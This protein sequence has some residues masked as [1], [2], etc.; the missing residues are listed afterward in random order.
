MPHEEKP[1]SIALNGVRRIVL[2]CTP[3]Q[4]AV[5]AL[6]HLLTEGWI[7]NLDDVGAISVSEDETGGLTVFVEADAEQVE[8]TEMVRRHQTLHGC[9][10]RH[11]LD[12]DPFMVTPVDS[13]GIPLDGVHLLRALFTAVDDMAPGGGVHACSISDGERL[14]FTST[15]VARHC[16][17]DRAVGLGIREGD[18]AGM[19]LVSTARISGAMALKAARAGLGWIAS[20]SVATT[21]ASEIADAFGVLLIERAGKSHLRT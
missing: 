20:R 17:L 19:G 15:D 12:C 3:T 11:V 6:G 4:P 8:T 16:A 21:L 7:R 2:S 1:I 14:V 10:L 18:I 9:G 13:P 5:L